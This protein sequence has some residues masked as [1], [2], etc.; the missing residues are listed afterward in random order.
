M[1]DNQFLALLEKDRPRIEP[2][3]A[4]YFDKELWFNNAKAVWNAIQRDEKLRAC[5][6]QSLVNCVEEAARRGLEIGGPNKH[7]A[8]V[9]FKTTAILITQWQGKAFIWMK[10]GA[11]KKLVPHVV[12]EGEKFEIYQGDE[13]RIVH[14][15]ALDLDQH[16][17]KWL[18]DIKNIVGAYAI[19]TLWSGER[20]RSFV[21]RAYMI[22]L[23]EW[24][25]KKNQ[26]SLG[27]GYGDWLPEMCMKTAVHRLEGKI[28]PPPH[29]DPEQLAAWLR[30]SAAPSVDAEYEHVETDLPPD[31]LPTD[32]RVA[33]TE[34]RRPRNAQVAGSTPAAS[35]RLV[36]SPDAAQASAGAGNTKG[37]SGRSVPDSN[38]A[39]AALIDEA[40]VTMLT[41]MYRQRHNGKLTG[42][43][44]WLTE[45]MDVEDFA[46]L[47][48]DQVDECASKLGED[49]PS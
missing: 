18:N 40:S 30:A 6:P 12:Y 29:M 11:I 5:S 33:Q 41:G 25:A 37:E 46:E 27:F 42:V 43:A 38:P 17:A 32:A 9:A 23:M 34:E 16:P 13:D 36:L 39:S 19:A 21:S 47:R 2:L 22:R 44:D 35:S 28:Q 1:A 20:V 48:A 45:Y 8:P 4:P 26:G 49:I 31:N 7:C 14:I 10:S 15:P 3:I 24:V